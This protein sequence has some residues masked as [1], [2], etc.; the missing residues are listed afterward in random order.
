MT[1]PSR[2]QA[3]AFLDRWGSRVIIVCAV[4]TGVNFIGLAVALVLISGQA[5]EGANARARQ[6]RTFP[7]SC[8]LYIDGFDR[9]VI[10]A[11]DLEVFES[12]QRCPRH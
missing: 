12:P 3:W 4:V 6:Q 8:K 9:G 10:T 7:V 2:G 11:H 5:G 1:S